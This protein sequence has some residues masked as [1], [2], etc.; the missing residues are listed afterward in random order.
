MESSAFIEKESVYK[1]SSADDFR[2]LGARVRVRLTRTYKEKGRSRE[3]SFFNGI[4]L[5]QRRFPKTVFGAMGLH[6]QDHFVLGDEEDHF[7]LLARMEGLSL[8]PLVS[9]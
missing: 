7:G 8:S 4:F 1:N 3:S 6:R 9:Q 2:P 5:F